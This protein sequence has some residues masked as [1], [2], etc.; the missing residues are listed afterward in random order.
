MAAFGEL[1]RS[2]I[3]EIDSKGHVQPSSTRYDEARAGECAMVCGR[4]IKP[5][6]SG[7]IVTTCPFLCIK[8]RMRQQVIN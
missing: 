6:A 7:S 4:A 5:L 2:A 1:Q 3:A 8:A